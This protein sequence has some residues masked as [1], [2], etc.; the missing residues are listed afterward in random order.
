MIRPVNPLLHIASLL[1]CSFT[2]TALAQLSPT[3]SPSPS[4]SQGPATSVRN[5]APEV[6]QASRQ[7][8]S[9]VQDNRGILY[10][11]NAS[12]VLEFDG[13][14]WR[15][16]KL[17]GELGATA[18]AKSSDGRI[19]VGGQGEI[20]W[21]APDDT[22][23]MMYVSKSSGLPVDFRSTNDRVIQIF[24]TPKGQVYLADHWLFLRAPNG[25][26][27]VVHAD[28]HFMQAAWFQNSLYVIDSSRGL[29]RLDGGTLQPVPGGAHTRA[30]AMLPSDAGLIIPS[31][32]DGLIRYS[33]DSASPWQVLDSAGW[34][35][36]DSADVTAG[37]VINKNLFAFGT[38]KHGVTLI[39]SAGDIV[40]HFDSTLGLADPHIYGLFYDHR[41]GL[42]LALA[43]GVSLVGL[44]VPPDADAVPFTAWVR[45]FVGTSNEHLFFGGTHATADGLPQLLQDLKQILKFPYNYNA[46]RF[47]YSANGLTS[48]GNL[49]FQTYMQGVD[50]GWSAWSSRT[51]R[52]FTTLPPGNWTFHVRARNA[53]GTVSRE[54]TYA[55][56]ILHAWYDTWWFA[57]VQV[58][59]VL[60]LLHLPGHAHQNKVLQDALT[61]F[62]VIVP[63]I[64]IGN[65]LSGLVTHYISS[66]VGVLN[67]LMS[68]VLAF[69]LDPMQNLLKKGVEHRNRKRR[70][71]HL[72]KHGLPID[73]VENADH[74]DHPHGHE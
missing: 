17:P 72:A 74:H 51:E 47:Q 46:F 12:G 54:D 65:A 20:G 22:G 28:D 24:D 71:R 73:H 35:P 44:N 55:F 61:T 1:L 13:T 66:N 2:P 60:L 67:V 10:I 6:Y 18:L 69:L 21:L 25:A 41:G 16:I 19:L 49:E 26:L 45:S 42:W 14:R 15:L 32:N 8:F 62:G 5:F 23:T 31:Y 29:T 34:G 52:E 3:P 48:T 50:T 64:Y 11:A 9:I 30:L 53:A 68:S 4:P 33:P 59:F 37:I 7:N 38:A 63:F 27:T 40:Q 36:F 70:E 39:N 43:N 58:I 56:R 57:A